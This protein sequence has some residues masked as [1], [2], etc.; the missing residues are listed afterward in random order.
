MHLQNVCVDTAADEPSKVEYK[1]LTYNDNYTTSAPH[2]R[3]I[4]APLA[5]SRTWPSRSRSWRTSA[6]TRATGRRR[7][8]RRPKKPAPCP[9]CRRRGKSTTTCYS[10]S[11]T[12][13]RQRLRWRSLRVHHPNT[14]ENK[15]MF[16]IL[17]KFNILTI[18]TT[19]G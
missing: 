8:A 4:P 1:G 9:K 14:G 17:A 13:Q 19:S 11:P 5:R 3:L 16:V 18:P 12:G 2:A 15:L 6:Q 10:A 7:A